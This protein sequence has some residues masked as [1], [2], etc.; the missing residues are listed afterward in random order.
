MRLIYVALYDRARNR[1]TL[2][3][4]K[5]IWQS[6]IFLCNSLWSV[7]PMSACDVFIQSLLNSVLCNIVVCNRCTLLQ[8][9]TRF[10]SMLLFTTGPWDGENQISQRSLK[11]N[12]GAVCF[13]VLPVGFK[14]SGLHCSGTAE[15]AGHRRARAA[16]PAGESE[17]GKGGWAPTFVLYNLPWFVH[18]IH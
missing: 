6:T 18:S 11:L 2:D 17:T 15:K 7:I 1:S 9:L 3:L 16:W 13:W 10:G 4:T 5:F 14:K 8:V 12:Q